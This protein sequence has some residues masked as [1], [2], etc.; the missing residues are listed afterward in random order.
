MKYN[1]ERRKLTEIAQEVV[2]ELTTLAKEKGLKIVLKSAKNIPLA[3]L[4]YDSIRQVMVNFIDNSI[5]YSDA[6]AS[7]C[8]DK[9]SAQAGKGV[10][11]VKVETAN[12]KRVKE[13]IGKSQQYKD[14]KLNLK[15]GNRYIV[16]SVSDKGRG[17][18]EDDQYR[19][20][21]KFARGECRGVLQY[22]PTIT[23]HTEGTGLGLYVCKSPLIP[24]YERGKKR[25]A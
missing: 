19:L 15:S 7:A 14:D 18:T 23:V 17:V 22:A 9:Q 10:I 5:K 21:K 1:F 12:G 3:L 16:F 6:S 2:N 4:D 20:F 25:S 11:D 8:A 13:L 24:L